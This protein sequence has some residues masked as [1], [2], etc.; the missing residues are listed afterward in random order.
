MENNNDIMRQYGLS[1]TVIKSA[2]Q[3]ADLTTARV[4]SQEKGSYRLVSSQ[5]EK[6]GEISGRFHYDVQAKSE[7]PA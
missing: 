5:G 3:S 2:E 6:W 4:L 1:E 7:Y